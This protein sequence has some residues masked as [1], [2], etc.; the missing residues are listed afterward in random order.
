MHPHPSHLVV[1]PYG[2]SDGAHALAGGHTAEAGCRLSLETPE[3]NGLQDDPS[4][5]TMAQ[6]YRASVTKI[7]RDNT[8]MLSLG[9]ARDITARRLGRP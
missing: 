9:Q 3:E 2:T 1:R 6:E 4:A 5:P 8:Y 7:L